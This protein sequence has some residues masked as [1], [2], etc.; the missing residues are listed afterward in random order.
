MLGP[1]T[2]KAPNAEL[3]YEPLARIDY[4]NGAVVEPWLA[5]EMTFDAAGRTLTIDIRDDVTFSDGE[6]LT[7]DDV[8]YSLSL[9][10]DKPELNLAGVTYTGVD[11]V[12]DDTVDVT[13]DSPSFAAL[14]QFASSSLPMVPEHIWKEQ[15]LATWTNP[16][17]VGTGPFTL[18]AFAA[19]QVTLKAREDY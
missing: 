8:A 9:P 5:E 10:L 11:K 1:A 15:D 7:A 2:E 3:I 17:P 4:S 19:Q 14:N 6:P 18:D 12:D 16:D 13:F